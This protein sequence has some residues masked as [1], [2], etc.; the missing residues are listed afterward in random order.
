MAVK[1]KRIA[2]YAEE[3]QRTLDF[4]RMLGLEIPASANE[5]HH[6][7]VEHHGLR[8]AFDTRE[9]AQ[10]VLGSWEGPVGYRMEL[11]F[12]F[13]SREALD[14]TYRRLTARGSI[15]HLE[16]RDTPWGERYAI[17]KDPD[18]NLISLVA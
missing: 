17:V 13:D 15:G 16:P 2:I 6:V 4:Y 18:G 14:E 7:E 11:A 1:V 10:A 3:L 9:S 12:Q 8:L 5:E